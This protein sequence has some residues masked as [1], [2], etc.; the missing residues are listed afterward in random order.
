MKQ[1]RLLILMGILSLNANFSRAQY[2]ALELVPSLYIPVSH[3]TQYYAIGFAAD[4]N[5]YYTD[6]SNYSLYGGLGFYNKRRKEESPYPPFYGIRFFYGAQYK[7]QIIENQFNISLGAE[8]GYQMGIHAGNSSTGTSIVFESA[9]GA[10][11][12]LGFNWR[13]DEGFFEIGAQVKYNIYL[14]VSGGYYFGSYAE[15]IHQWVQ[16]AIGLKIYI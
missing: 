9:L 7:F 10:S 11:P 2:D 13:I 14:P 15:S 8:G 5:Y 12:R 1:F 6:E 4:F 3:Q 16:P